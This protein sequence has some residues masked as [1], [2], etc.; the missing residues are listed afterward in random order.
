MR[1]KNLVF[2]VI[3][4]SIVRII[5]EHWA[6][7]MDKNTGR[8]LCMAPT[9]GAKGKRQMLGPREIATSQSAAKQITY[10]PRRRAI[11]ATKS[12]PTGVAATKTYKNIIFRAVSAKE[13]RSPTR[14]SPKNNK[15]QGR[16]ASTNNNHSPVEWH[17]KNPQNFWG[18]AEGGHEQ[19]IVGPRGG[20]K[21]SGSE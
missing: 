20:R 10:I 17:R 1:E 3:F 8:H 13:K 21:N 4:F 2:A 6:R 14:S 9:R 18:V 5:S 16:A 7:S 11:S 19:K 12:S 15:A